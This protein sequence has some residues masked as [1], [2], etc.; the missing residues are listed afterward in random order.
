VRFERV[1][2][3]D[4]E[5]TKAERENR[6]KPELE[7]SRKKK[8]ERTSPSKYILCILYLKAEQGRIN[9]FNNIMW[10]NSFKEQSRKGWSLKKPLK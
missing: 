7:Q 6:K 8:A 10:P 9:K 5:K 4:A 1:T 3:N 2:H